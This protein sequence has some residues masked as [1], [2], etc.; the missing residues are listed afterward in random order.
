M[1]DYVQ[2]KSISDEYNDLLGYVHELENVLRQILEYPCGHD[3][4]CEW[5][6]EYLCDCGVSR[7]V[8]GAKA[9][10]N[11]RNTESAK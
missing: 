9:M 2:R 5:Q 3:P 6:G 8:R 10:L 7:K 1:S 11:K 4:E